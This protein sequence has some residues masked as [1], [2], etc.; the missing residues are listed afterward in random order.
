MSY[1]VIQQV[2]VDV[3][4]AIPAPTVF[5]K[6]ADNVVRV[7]RVLIQDN[8][9]DYAIPAGFTARLRGTKAD[10][11]RIYLDARSQ[12]GNV[13][14]FVL[15]QNALAANGKAICEVELSDAAGDVV[16]TCNLVLNVQQAAMD[17]DAVESTDEFKSLEAAK[18][19]AETAAKSAAK[20]AEQTATDKKSAAESAAAA[21]EA[22]EKAGEAATDVINTGVAEKLAEMRQIS[23][24]VTEKRDNVNTAAATATKARDDA[25]AAQAAAAGSAADAETARKAAAELAEQA[26]AAA[27]QAQGYAGAATFAIGRDANGMLTLFMDNG[28]G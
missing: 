3:S 2:T 28:E 17:D 14:E 25:Q 27:T 20:N 18:A 24:D 1:E 6:Q 16:K 23:A 26:K 11:T 9:A 15:T 8:K 21:K 5:C 13:A 22:A 4:K 12:T 7:L 10:E 19:A